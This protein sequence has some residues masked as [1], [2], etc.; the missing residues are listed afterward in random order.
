MSDEFQRIVNQI[1]GRWRAAL[2][3]IADAED[4][5]SWRPIGQLHGRLEA[6][7]GSGNIELEVRPARSGDASVSVVMQVDTALSFH[8]WLGE[9]LLVVN[10][11]TDRGEG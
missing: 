2:G 1:E 8:R 6:R 4:G 9:Q 10:G 11:T 5:I 3:A 7:L